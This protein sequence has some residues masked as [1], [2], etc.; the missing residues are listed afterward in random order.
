MVMAQQV[1][2]AMQRLEQIYGEDRMKE[3]A[4]RFPLGQQLLLAQLASKLNK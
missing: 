3:S 2:E 4:T 1:K